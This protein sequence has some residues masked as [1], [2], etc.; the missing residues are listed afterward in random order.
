MNVREY[1][2]QAFPGHVYQR[3]RDPKDLESMPLD[4][5]CGSD[6]KACIDAGIKLADHVR[7]A[8]GS[9]YPDNLMHIRNVI[10]NVCGCY[11]CG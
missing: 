4:S 3:A 6:C 7:M 8:F 2:E 10:V 9:D 1:F 5:N 11:I